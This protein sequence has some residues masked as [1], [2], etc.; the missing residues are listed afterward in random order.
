MALKMSQL[1]WFI[2][3]DTRYPFRVEA[4]GLEAER[5]IVRNPG[6][7]FNNAQHSHQIQRPGLTFVRYV[8]QF[9]LHAELHYI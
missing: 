8:E 2:Y 9:A 6:W 1:P 4:R 7:G 3:V 5:A